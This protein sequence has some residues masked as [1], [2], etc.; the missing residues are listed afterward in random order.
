MRTNLK[1]ISELPDLK[2]LRYC[3]LK[4]HNSINKP[5]VVKY[6]LYVLAQ[7][8]SLT[9]MWTQGASSMKRQSTC[10]RRGT[11]CPCRVAEHTSSGSV[12]KAGGG[13]VIIPLC[14]FFENK[15]RKIETLGD[16]TQ[17]LTGRN[18]EVGREANSDGRTRKMELKLHRAVSK[19]FEKHLSCDSGQS[20]I[21]LYQICRQC[22]ENKDISGG[23]FIL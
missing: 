12:P 4:S 1:L 23:T 13:V 16:S 9:R 8:T 5:I 6:L 20:T 3:N 15:G 21:T 2:Q 10:W 14:C 19:G 11:Q 22:C 7:H 17:P 18:W